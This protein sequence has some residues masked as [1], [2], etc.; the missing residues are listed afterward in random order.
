MKQVFKL[1][2]SKAVKN[3]LPE[4]GRDCWIHKTNDLPLPEWGYYFDENG[5][6]LHDP[7]TSKNGILEEDG[8][9]YYYVDGIKAPAG[10]IKIGDD[11]YYVNSNGKL[12]V[13][14]TYYCSRMN[15]LLPEGTYAFEA[16]GK[17]IPG[18]TDK[19][20]IGDLSIAV[21]I[22][23][24]IVPVERIVVIVSFFDIPIS[25]IA[26]T[27]TVEIVQIAV[28]GIPPFSYGAIRHS[29]M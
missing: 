7:D 2:V 6:I 16:D 1:E 8:V 24:K 19:N 18:A 17:L 12:I 3:L 14:Q 11:Y 21:V 28:N 9:Q 25:L 27:F 26:V 13:D 10:M 4:G 29:K 5:V 22:R 15:D 23:T 20:G